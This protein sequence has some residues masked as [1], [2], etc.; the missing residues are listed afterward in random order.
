[1]KMMD[2]VVA[3]PTVADAEVAA[4]L[5]HGMSD[6]TRLRILLTLMSHEQRVT[7]L[8]AAIGTSQS[9]VSGH[10]ACLRDCGLVTSR[11]EGRQNYY[12]IAAADVTELLSAAQRLLAAVGPAVALCPNLETSDA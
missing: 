3:V 1:M 10:L 9:N 2:M 6:P 5:F 4:K 11:P 7:D 12:S 8:V